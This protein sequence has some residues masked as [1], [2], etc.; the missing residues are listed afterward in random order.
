MSSLSVPCKA[1]NSTVRA[2]CN[3]DSS[4]H[5]N[6]SFSEGG[7][8][9]RRREDGREEEGAIGEDE[10]R[11][12]ERMRG[13]RPLLTLSRRMI[14]ERFPPFVYVSPPFPKDSAHV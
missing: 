9:G 1:K 11:E 6:F 4:M 3:N 13:W 5:L 14:G 8:R 7:Q 2:F 10:V 12:R